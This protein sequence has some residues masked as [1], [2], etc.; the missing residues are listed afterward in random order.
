MFVH[1]S[2]ITPALDCLMNKPNVSHSTVATRFTEAQTLLKQ[3]HDLL[4]SIQAEPYIPSIRQ[5]QLAFLSDKVDNLQSN[6][7]TMAM[8]LAHLG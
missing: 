2:D 6:C 4:D 1:Q 7:H 3:V 8:Q 5:N